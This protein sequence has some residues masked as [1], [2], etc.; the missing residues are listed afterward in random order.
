MSQDFLVITAFLAVTVCVP[1]FIAVFVFNFEPSLPTLFLLFLSSFLAIHPAFGFSIPSYLKLQK[2]AKPQLQV[3]T[4]K[5]AP[6]VEIIMMMIAE[7][8]I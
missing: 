3:P 8:K 5:E 7:I 1:S 6:K 4:A 2:A